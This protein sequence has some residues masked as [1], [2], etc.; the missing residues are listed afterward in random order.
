[1]V[2]EF[3]LACWLPFDHRNRDDSQACCRRRV[4]AW[5]CPMRKLVLETTSPF[6]GLPELMAFDEALFAREGRTIEGSERD[7]AGIK[8]AAAKVIDPAGFGPFA[9]HG[10]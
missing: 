2:V 5:R 6:Q 4:P 7:E 8:T 10:T 9:S 3:S 1:M